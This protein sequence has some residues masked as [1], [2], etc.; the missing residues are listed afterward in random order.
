M[1]RKIIPVEIASKGVY[2]IA[3]VPPRKAENIF[4]LN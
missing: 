4:K 2:D 1:Y 3:E